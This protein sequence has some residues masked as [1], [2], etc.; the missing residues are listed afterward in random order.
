MLSFLTMSWTHPFEGPIKL[1][2][3]ESVNPSSVMKS[4]HCDLRNAGAHWY[5][6]PT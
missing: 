3:K 2:L 6:V 1:V 4:S 5:E